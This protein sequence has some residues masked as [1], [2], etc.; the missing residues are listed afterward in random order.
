MFRS[1]I[2]G[3][4]LAVPALFLISC[5]GENEG[6]DLITLIG[7]EINGSDIFGENQNVAS[8]ATITLT[9]S[10]TLNPEA[11]ED[12]LT[13]EGNGQNPDFSVT[14]QNAGSRAVVSAVLV[15]ETTYQV[16][17]Q[18]VIGSQGEALDSPLSFSFRTATD[19]EIITE[20]DPCT[21]SGEACTRILTLTDGTATN[22]FEYFSNYPIYRENARR[23]KLKNAVIVIH[24]V[25]RN[26][27]DYFSWVGSSLRDEGLEGETILISPKFKVEDEAD[28]D[29]MY[30]SRFGWREG[31]NALSDLKLSSFA[32]I[33]S[34]V[35]R[36]SDTDAFP[37]LENIVITG[38]SSGG[39]FTHVYAA[40]NR[41]DANTLDI[42]M[43]Y[44]VANSQYFY[45]PDGQRINE[46]TGQLYTPNDCTGYDFWPLGYANA[47][48][49][50]SALTASEVNDQL[51]SRSVLYFLG[52]GSGSDGSLNDTNCTA[53]L[54]GAT[55]FSRGE[56]MFDYM[57]MK[58][59]AN[60]HEK[61]I[62]EG[63]GHDGRAMY[64]SEEFEVLIQELLN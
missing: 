3:V 29:E 26:A 16:S 28:N 62:V 22:S 38:H 1:A 34:L 46:T 58:Y 59:P 40:A 14:Y 5:N 32:V 44:V 15:P 7:G 31:D 2:L 48:S 49:Y 51:I 21:S 19:N 9:L 55:R 13:L 12:A 27:G 36:L 60:T 56:N 37:V 8:E 52:N 25:N 11:F 64:Q 10:S 18:G 6:V 42:N 35:T 39:L 30:W 63:I 20:M 43:D 53:T 4:A 23:E 45:Y 47:P 24:G 41:M 54:L 33:D 50:V 61:R 17:L 57:E